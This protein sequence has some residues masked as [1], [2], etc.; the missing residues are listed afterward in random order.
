MIRAKSRMH[1]KSKSFSCQNTRGSHQE[2]KKFHTVH[3]AAYRD[4]GENVEPPRDK[5]IR[6]LK[7]LRIIVGFC[8][9]LKR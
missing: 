4:P 1:S 9:A 6:I 3:Q 5:L 7:G 8:L 2:W